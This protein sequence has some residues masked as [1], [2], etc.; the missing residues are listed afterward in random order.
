[1]PCSPVM[2]LPMCTPVRCYFVPMWI[3]TLGSNAFVTILSH[4]CP[5]SHWLL[6]R[7]LHS[8]LGLISGGKEC[9]EHTEC[10]CLHWLLKHMCS[11]CCALHA[12]PF[13]T[14]LLFIFILLF[15]HRCYC[16]TYPVSAN[17]SPNPSLCG[18]CQ[19]DIAS[20]YV[21]N[22]ALHRIRAL[23]PRL[24][25]VF[26]DSCKCTL[27]CSLIVW[28]GCFN[29]WSYKVLKCTVTLTICVFK[30]RMS[31]LA[32]IANLERS[33]HTTTVFEMGTE[34]FFVGVL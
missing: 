21:A 27:V 2:P 33:L 9:G 11:A 31:I 16:S 25:G 34:A 30:I 24:G 14:V 22:P 7:A 10:D 5:I 13:A 26:C 17:F 18:I 23:L 20:S 3:E 15:P 32:T 28:L 6:F 1:M 19:V 12:R 4:L 8:W 29:V